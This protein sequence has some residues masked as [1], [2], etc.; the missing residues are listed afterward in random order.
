MMGKAK[1]RHML[2]SAPT[3]EERATWQIDVGIR[4]LAMTG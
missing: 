2:F 4:L 3:E 1:S